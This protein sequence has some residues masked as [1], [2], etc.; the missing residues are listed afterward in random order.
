M[1]QRVTKKELLKSE[2]EVLETHDP[3]IFFEA[4][5]ISLRGNTMHSLDNKRMD[6]QKTVFKRWFSLYDKHLRE[7]LKVQFEESRKN[8]GDY[9]A[10]L[11]A[12]ELKALSTLPTRAVQ[13]GVLIDMKL[14]YD[15][16]RELES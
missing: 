11:R 16:I 15:R 14:V 10:G 13:R 8:S 2:F 12:G 7:T 1:A 3:E 5:L 6:L 9:I 4:M